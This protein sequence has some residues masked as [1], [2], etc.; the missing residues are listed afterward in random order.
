MSNEDVN[1]DIDMIF[2]MKSH[3]ENHDQP[4]EGIDF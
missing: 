2:R 3:Y 1:N 4:K